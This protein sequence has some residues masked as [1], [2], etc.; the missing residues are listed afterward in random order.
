[1]RAAVKGASLIATP[2][3]REVKH[4]AP[5][6][7]YDRYVRSKEIISTLARQFDFETYF[8]IQPVPGYR[9]GFLKHQFMNESDSEYWNRHTPSRMKLLEETVDDERSFSLAHLLE[10]YPRQPFVDR[11]HYTAEVCDMVARAISERMEIP[12]ASE[13]GS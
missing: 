9:N 8:F 2:P 5:A 7:I 3:R 13:T 4:K 10:G 1:M 11:V 12:R 6:E